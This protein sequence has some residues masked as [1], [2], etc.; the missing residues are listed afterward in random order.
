M[1]G[2]LKYVYSQKEIPKQ[3]KTLEFIDIF[4]EMPHL[5]GRVGWELRIVGKGLTGAEGSLWETAAVKLLPEGSNF[6]SKP[7]T[8]KRCV[9]LPGSG[10]SMSSA[11]GSLWD[12]ADDM[13]MPRHPIMP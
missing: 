4:K 8:K 9:V 11:E 5:K 6:Q 13:L 3:T 7:R 1:F 10:L 12:T 2:I